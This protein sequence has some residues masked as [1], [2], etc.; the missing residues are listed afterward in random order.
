[1]T[2]RP[3]ALPWCSRVRCNLV[4]APFRVARGNW[5]LGESTLPA[6]RLFLSGTLDGIT[7]PLG[8]GMNRSAAVSCY[9]RPPR[10]P[11]V[12]ETTPYRGNSF[13][14]RKGNAAGPSVDETRT[15]GEFGDP[16]VAAAPAE[17]R[18]S[19]NAESGIS[20]GA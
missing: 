18:T 9:C 13:D 10:A 3:S 11:I 16:C 19:R 1:M 4:P 20:Y 6:N 5:N 7:T 15:W 8:R 17:A 14:F 2:R 12:L